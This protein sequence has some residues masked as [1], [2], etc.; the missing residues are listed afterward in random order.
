MRIV[1]AGAGEVGSHLAKMLSA[2][3]HDITVIDS[4][5]KNLDMIGAVADVTTYCGDITT[6]SLLGKAEVD[7][8][9]LFIAV[10]QDENSNLISAMMAHQLGSKKVVVRIDHEEYLEPGNKEV[11]INM[12]IDY[13]F[14]PEKEA[15]KEVINLLGYTSTTEYVDF[16]DSNLALVAFKIEINSPLVS[17]PLQFL[18]DSQSG[19]TLNY[20]T[21]AIARGTET[22][23]P[24]GSDYIRLGDVIY[25]MT[26]LESIPEVMKFTGK[27]QVKI[28]NLMILGG[29]KVARRIIEKLQGD[30]N[31]KLIDYNLDKANRIA[32]MFDKVLVINDDGRNIDVMDQEGLGNMDA[33]LALT[34]RAET[35]I[36]ASMLAKRKGVRKIV[37][38]VENID[39]IGLAESI[40]VDTIINKKLLTASSIFRFTMNTEVRTIRCLNACDA[41]VLEFT[42]KS[43]SLSTQR[44]LR[45]MGFPSGAVVGGLVRSGRAIIASGDTEI[46][47]HDR[48]VVFALPQTIAKVGRFFE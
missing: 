4:S 36:L 33:F 26:N 28:K 5:N 18:N 25:I 12:G 1:I 35:N 46:K 11:F 9:D 23:I 22:I 21:V 20:R 2:E 10:S 41:E 7:R 15:A 48:V 29:S 14:H 13:M 38:E 31:I 40:G 3:N 27:Q 34:G 30:I 39:Y 6:F 17:K 42:A 43:D 8:S 24:S 32:E 16:A 47:A 44:P 45:D 37:A 19:D